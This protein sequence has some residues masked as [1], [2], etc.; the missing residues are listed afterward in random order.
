MDPGVIGTMIPIFFFAMIAAIV[1][2]PRYFQSLERQKMAETLKAA[3]EKGQP[4]PTEV[5]DAISSGVRTPPSPQR[6]LRTGIVW[7]GV[8]VGLAAMGWAIG[9]E[10]PDA[11]FPMI[12]IACFP[13]FIGLAFI[14]MFFVSRGRQ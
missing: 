11:T 7:L 14:V 3:I 10:E 2:V 13:A 4:L 5:V 1:I 8:G 6:D 12:G 9:F